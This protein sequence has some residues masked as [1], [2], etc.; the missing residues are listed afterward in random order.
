MHFPLPCLARVSFLWRK[1]ENLIFIFR[2]YFHMRKENCWIAFF[3]FCHVQI[4]AQ[5]LVY[6][7]H[8]STALP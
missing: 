4:F 3:S 1:E 7:S 2:P 6:F 5:I 8:N